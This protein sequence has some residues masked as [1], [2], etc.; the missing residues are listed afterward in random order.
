[1]MKLKK[2]IENKIKK[3]NNNEL[4]ILINELC[5]INEDNIK[6]LNNS[7]SNA[8]INVD[9]EINKIDK[10]FYSVNI[11]LNK[12]LNIYWELNRTYKDYKGICEIGL[13]LLENIDMFYDCY[14]DNIFE[15]IFE[16]SESIC[17]NILKINDNSIYINRIK[18][19]LDKFEYEG[20][21]ELYSYFDDL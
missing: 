21:F 15:I 20:L 2:T 16:L 1:M 17:S 7:L 4:I 13:H 11:N 10:C 9:K 3:M 6:Y 8:S 19:I 18:D 14:I 5:D 12:A